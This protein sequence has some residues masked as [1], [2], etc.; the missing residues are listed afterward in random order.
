[1]IELILELVILIG[2]VAK[3]YCLATLSQQGISAVIACDF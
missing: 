2:L 3:N 1:M